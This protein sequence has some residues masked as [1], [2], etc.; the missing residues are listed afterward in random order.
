[1]HA[2]GRLAYISHAYYSE[3]SVKLKKQLIVALQELYGEVATEPPAAALHV[4]AK[5]RRRL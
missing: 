3:Q 2:P 5:M 4:G 1:M